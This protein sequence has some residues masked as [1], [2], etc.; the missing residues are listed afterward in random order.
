MASNNG[1]ARKEQRRSVARK[2]FALNPER[3]ND[4]EYLARK[5]VE[6]KALH[7]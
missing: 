7:A 2:N 3:M 4:K 5:E 6:H 1:K